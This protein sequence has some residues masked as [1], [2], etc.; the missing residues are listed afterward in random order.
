MMLPDRKMILSEPEGPR[1]DNWFGRFVMKWKP[2]STP[3]L[4]G[5]T[6]W[7]DAEGKLKRHTG[8]SPST[9]WEDFG[10]VVIQKRVAFWPITQDSHP[11]KAWAAGTP[12]YGNPA[13][14]NTP[15][16]AGCRFLLLKAVEEHEREYHQE[17]VT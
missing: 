8:W 11:H 13:V 3:I 15:L 17:A 10:E 9:N 12:I 14:G 7:L 5:Q 16:L 2:Q 1:I 4:M 6:G